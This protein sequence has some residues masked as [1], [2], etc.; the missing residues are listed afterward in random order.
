MRSRWCCREAF[1]A[2]AGRAYSLVERQADARKQ[3]VLDETNLKP[4][5][6]PR[7]LVRYRMAFVVAAHALLFAL[8]LLAAFLLS[9]NFRWV[10]IRDN[11]P[12]SWFTELYLPLVGLAIPIKL[13][14]FHLAR[15]YRGSWRYVGL[16]DLFGVISAS[17]MGT[18]FFLLTYFVLENAWARYFGYALID[19]WPVQ[20]L[21]QSSVFALD[22][23]GTIA[24]VS[25]ARIVIRFYYE[26]IQP[27]A[28]VNPIRVLICGAGDAGEAVLRELLR[29]GR[30]RCVG[31]LD[32]TTLELGGRIHD[33]EIIGRTSQ[34]R[35]VCEQ[36]NVE[37]V[38]FALPKASP[39]AIRAIVERCQGTGVSF[40]TIPVMSDLMEGRV[41]VSRL[42][43][44]DIDDLLGREE[45]QL[46]LHEIGRQLQGKRILVTG[47]GGS[48]G[49]EM[50]RQIAAFAPQRL[51]LVEQAEN[52]LFEIDRE[53]R[54]RY[55]GLSI[56]PCVADITD[57]PRL[58]GIFERERPSSVFHAAAHKH[59]P[60]ME[61]NPG[62]AIKNNI[63]GTMSVADACQ[64][65][66]VDKMVMISTDKAVNPTSVMGCTKRVAELYVQGLTG[67]GPTH[68]VT[69]RFG[70]VLGS[71]G[72][73]V[74]IFR[75]QIAEGGPVTVTHPE[76]TRYFMTI[77]EAAQLVLQAGTMG[78]GGEIY[79]LQMGEPV[80]IVDLARDMITLSGLRP[81]VDIEIVFTGKR[82]GEKLYEELA[83]EGENVGDT[84]HPKIGIWK[85]R[86]ADRK[87]VCHGIERLLRMTD[88]GTLEQIQD[89]LKAVVPE[90][91][92]NGEHEAVDVRPAL[93]AAAV[94]RSVASVAPVR[95]FPA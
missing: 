49:S 38:L 4:P 57:A 86:P 26:D 3:S 78:Q 46:D 70:N 72:S 61:F 73:V 50:C 65:F 48:I 19:Q 67:K 95:P 77:P 34:I 31:F 64:E 84:S 42:R 5:P 71:S 6:L 93:N 2:G 15:Q 28:A 25:A 21:R 54:G 55:P 32:D 53:L 59:V 17:L 94:E 10:I 36:Y 35:E 39:R 44:I 20:N 33:C 81:D 75:K 82:P 74:P 12:Y 16:R 40:R 14:V 8:A 51:V 87:A 11:V 69:V 43:E 47:A 85:H 76:M 52:N 41:Q 56:V 37:Q 29:I 60:M 13:V 80:K 88:S 1:G 9:Y 83:N 30:Y 68:F 92:P 24:L 27:R 79:V 62:E 58:R 18:F 45:V 66:G 7:V 63:A 90:Y 91:L 23:A 22:W 89:A